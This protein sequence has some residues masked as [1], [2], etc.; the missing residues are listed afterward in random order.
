MS[1]W[2]EKIGK[3]GNFYCTWGKKYHFGIGGRDKN[4]IFWAMYT[5]LPTCGHVEGAGIEDELAALVPVHLGQ[6]SEPKNTG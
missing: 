6:L 5:P 3:I 4:I 2:L 1:N